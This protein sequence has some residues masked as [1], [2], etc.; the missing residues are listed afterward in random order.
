MPEQKKQVEECDAMYKGGQTS[1]QF[2][3]KSLEIEKF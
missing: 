3:I 1:E 2:G